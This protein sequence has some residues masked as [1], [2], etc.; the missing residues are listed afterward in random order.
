MAEL[1]DF[2]FLFWLV[3]TVAVYI[4]GSIYEKHLKEKSKAEAKRQKRLESLSRVDDWRPTSNNR[5]LGNYSTNDLHC[6]DAPSLSARTS[7]QYNSSYQYNDTNTQVPASSH[8]PLN[9]GSSYQY[10]NP[11]ETHASSN[12]YVASSGL[13]QTDFGHYDSSPANYSREPGQFSS[14]SALGTSQRIGGA[15]DCAIPTAAGFNGDCVDWVNRILFLFYSQANKYGPIIAENVYRSLNEKLANIFNSSIEF[16]NWMIEFQSI[17]LSASSRPELKNVR[18]ESESDKSVSAVCKIYNQRLV[19]NMKLQKARQST[20]RGYSDSFQEDAPFEYELTLENLE[21]KLKSVAMLNDKLIVV[22]FMEK[23]DTKILLKL[24]NNRSASGLPMSEDALV[25]LILQA[26]TQVVVDLYFGDDPEFPQF[27]K[28]QSGYKNKLSQLKGSANE[29][30]RQIKHD[31][32]GALSLADNKE[33]KI[34]VKLLRAT[35]IN[36]NQNVTCIIELA[37]PKQHAISST[38]QGSNPFWDEHFLFSI[39]DKSSTELILELWDSLDQALIKSKQQQQQDSSARNAKSFSQKS[40][41][42]AELTASGKFLGLARV[43]IDELRRNPVQKRT[44]MLQSRAENTHEPRATNILG[45]MD[46]SDSIGGELHL[47]LMFLEHSSQ[48]SGTIQKSASASS[49]NSVGADQGDVV[50]VDRKLTPSGY[51]ITTT[52]IAK[53]ASSGQQQHR[54]A[55]SKDRLSPSGQPGNHSPVSSL[56]EQSGAGNEMSLDGFSAQMSQRSGDQGS[57]LQHGEGDEDCRTDSR[58]SRS[59]TRSGGFLRAIKRRFSFSRSR[60][61]RSASESAGAFSQRAQSQSAMGQ[62][63]LDAIS[64]DSRS[65]ASSEMSIS[66]R[67]KSMPASRDSNEVPTI[68]INKSR[69]SDASSAF[70]FAQPKSQLVI[71]CQEPKM[72]VD[73]GAKERTLLRHY[74]IPDDPASERRWRR[75][76]LKL[77]LFN[78]HQFVACHLA[79]SSTCH[80]CGRVFSRRPGKQGYKCRNCHLLSHKQCHVKVD[81]NCPYATKD[82][83]KLEYIDADPPA[84]LVFEKAHSTGSQQQPRQQKPSRPTSRLAMKSISVEVDDR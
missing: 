26:L 49:I 77:H 4:V 35:N 23:P 12:S 21:G 34:F 83:L 14:Q 55:A 18:T 19:C 27:S 2:L 79:G 63:N 44:L 59:R 72:S 39:S 53:P 48:A 51:L 67:A 69:L 41:N 17:D 1:I 37:N 80:L 60:R 56:T 6:S 42:K 33:R 58:M 70:T 32:L 71:E 24:K 15:A 64:I 43:N 8:R 78:E 82:S 57:Q 76:G 25:S 62:H 22:Q 84:S 30:K 66:G 73:G 54:R 16:G 65:R 52:T 13:R 75:R 11:Y 50:S 31:F 46:L 40:F 7:S 36:Y 45:G 29:I 28:H 10:S 9:S 20:I 47:E 5:E 38:K 81:H 68:V 3:V 61:S 74:A